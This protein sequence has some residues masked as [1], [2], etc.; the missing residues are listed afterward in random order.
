MV[1][2][3]FHLIRITIIKSETDSPLVINRTRECL[4]HWEAITHRVTKGN[5]MPS[6]LNSPESAAK[7]GYAQG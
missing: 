5:T 3:D 2:T 1:I 6:P 4:D 7:I